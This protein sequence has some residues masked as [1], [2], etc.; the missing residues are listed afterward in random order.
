MALDHFIPSQRQ[1]DATTL[2]LCVLVRVPVLPIIDYQ[3]VGKFAKLAAESRYAL[4]AVG[5]DIE[6]VISSSVELA[7][8]MASPSVVLSKTVACM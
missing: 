8:P 6:G 5:I 7:T 4:A 1:Y 3:E 2:W